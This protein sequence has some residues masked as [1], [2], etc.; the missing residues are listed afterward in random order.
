MINSIN[1]LKQQLENSERDKT[2]LELELN[3]MKLDYDRMQEKLKIEQKICESKASSFRMVEE[4]LNKEINDLKEKLRK[5]R[6][7]MMNKL[8]LAK[9]QVDNGLIVIRALKNEMKLVDEAVNNPIK[10][11]RKRKST[12][13]PQS[14]KHQKVHGYSILSS[15]IGIFKSS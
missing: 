13:Y 15:F 6:L 1:N 5:D 12:Q 10:S 7:E 11:N 14:V 3:A 2:K 9:E 4:D 8:D